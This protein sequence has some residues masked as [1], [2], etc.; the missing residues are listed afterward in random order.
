MFATLYYQLFPV[1]V[2]T[3]CLS[4]LFV[5]A[6]EANWDLSKML[7]AIEHLLMQPPIGV[8]DMD[9]NENNYFNVPEYAM[10]VIQYLQVSAVDLGGL[11]GG[12]ADPL[13]PLR[14]NGEEP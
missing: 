9:S 4:D 12:G 6:V 1:F 14:R 13:G 11:G 5:Y 8:V 2:N 3:F 7:K 10:E